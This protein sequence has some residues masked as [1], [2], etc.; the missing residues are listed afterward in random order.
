MFDEFDDFFYSKV[1]RNS[2]LKPMKGSDIH[3]TI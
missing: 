2:K 3:K 1:S